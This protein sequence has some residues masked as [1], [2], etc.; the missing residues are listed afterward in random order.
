MKDSNRMI[1]VQNGVIG[2]REPRL[3]RIAVKSVGD[4]PGVSPAYLDVAQNYG[5][6]LAGPPLCDEHLALIQH[7]FTE[8]EAGVIR[9][10]RPKEAKTV[11]EMA[12]TAKRPA[13]EVR[14]ILDRLAE[15]KRI[16][17]SF[18][19]REARRYS[20]IPI[21]PGAF[22]TILVRTSMDSL[23][24]WHRRFA[25]L[26][27]RLYETGFVTDYVGK[28][29]PG[30]RYLPVGQS[31]SAHP[32]ALPF[33]YFAEVIGPYNDFAVG[34]CQC[35]LAEE[36]VG[37]GCGRPMDNCT[38]LGPLA[39]RE[40][41]H[42]LMRKVERR[43]LLE[44]KAEAEA[45]GL[46]TWT[47]N[48][49]IAGS[50]TACSCCGCCCHMMRTIS[51]FNL[52]G[53]IAPPHFMPESD[54]EKCSFCGKCAQACTMG[55]VTVDTKAKTRVFHAERCVGCGLCVVACSKDQALTLKPVPGYQPPEVK[56]SQR[57]SVLS[58]LS[59]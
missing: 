42:G 13:E 1:Q 17:I 21:L 5:P 25:E 14:P 49:E 2:P 18:G 41:K 50:N 10:L 40:V 6:D 55:A 12:E 37:R 24:A 11:E 52:P 23:T 4:Y 3:R 53:M 7:M 15:E 43:E 57:R 26:F 39:V 20:L 9:H 16:I 35:R 47:M 31:I 36:L 38:A 58:G 34:L 56:K 8:E 27:E 54:P 51:E 44:I 33:D 19:P 30:I 59:G 28:R 32:M 29:P 22:E 48:L 45:S 46:V